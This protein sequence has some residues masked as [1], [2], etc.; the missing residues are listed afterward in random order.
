MAAARFTFRAPQVS[1][2]MESEQSQNFNERLSQWV[3]NQGFWFQIR[4]SL[5]G[6]GT[7]GTAMFH[8]LRLSFRLLIFLLLA[9]A[10]SWL[11]LV[12]L[13]ETQTFSDKMEEK[14]RVGLSASE[15]E[16]TGFSRT[17]GKLEI[18]RLACQGGSDTFFSALEA[19]NIRCKMGLLDGITGPW[20]TGTV[21]IS[22]LDLE[23]RAGADDEDAAQML[24][25]AL[26]H[27]SD[28][29]LTD[30]LEIADASLRWGYSDRTRGAI[31]HSTLKIQ[32]QEDGLILS[33]KGGT[34]SQN[35]LRELEIVNL[36][37]ACNREGLTFEKAELR[38]GQGTV[39]LSGLTV[40]GGTNPTVTGSAKI[41]MLSLENLVP[42]ALRS[43]VEGTISGD[44]TIS[45]STNSTTGIGF[46][47]QVVL[48]GQDMISLRDR[49][50]LLKALSTVDYVRNY[51]RVD[52]REGSFQIKTTGGGMELSN[53]K[54]KAD[55]LFTLEGNM[56]VRLPTP[57]EINAAIRKGSVAGGSPLFS[58]DGGDTVSEVKE[59]DFTLRRAAQEAKR[60]KEGVR[61]DGGTSL[62]D[63]LA[64]NVEERQLS[65][66]ASD[67]SSRMLRYEGLFRVTLSADAF[68][69]APRLIQ[70]YPVDG[71]LGRIPIMVPIE[72][73]L[74]ELTLKQAEDIYQQGRR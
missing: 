4:Y 59:S 23:L 14:L 56:R 68:E 32:R 45:G 39:D 35:W 9:A 74:Y 54:L 33:F 41:R 51:H 31:H 10:G 11:Y 65:A 69:R 1:L 60:A 61:T 70:E 50:H 66:Q 13:A 47:G 72:G 20:K 40:S 24:A 71:N 22:A 27:K 28:K 62:S 25:E 46:T 36:V 42:P 37:I 16:I 7:K 29:V 64:A 18:N 2:N 34:F 55:D 44:F 57:E 12:K 19:R 38:R 21:S 53:L 58:G 3:A 52:F 17:Q 8:L 15:A 6:S 30:T 26:F 5:T 48:D 67:R 43:F 63:R 49:V 73:N